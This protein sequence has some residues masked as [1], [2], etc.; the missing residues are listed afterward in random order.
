MILYDLHS[1]DYITSNI[2]LYIN[3]IRGWY[4]IFQLAIR[5]TEASR[6][7]GRKIWWCSRG[8]KGLG[9][10]NPRSA[11]VRK[12][13]RSNHSKFTRL[14][15]RI[16]QSWM[17]SSKDS[18]L[19]TQFFSSTKVELFKLSLN[20]NHGKATQLYLSTKQKRK[21]AKFNITNP[22]VSYDPLHVNTIYFSCIKSNEIW[23]SNLEITFVNYFL[24]TC[25]ISEV[26]IQKL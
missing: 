26:T 17:H 15:K 10:M 14:P 25:S 3:N 6:H 9:P 13:H 1:E 21:G 11:S 20:Y 23:I 2:I 7:N 12:S 19:Y 16:N 5:E 22:V 8:F 18:K 24:S 4:G